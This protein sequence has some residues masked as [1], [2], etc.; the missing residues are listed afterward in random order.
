MHFPVLSGRLNKARHVLCAQCLAHVSARRIITIN[1]VA[2]RVRHG[3]VQRP[4]E[5]ASG[6]EGVAVP[7][8]TDAISESQQIR[9]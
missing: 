4:V 2:E 5:G 8:F 9:G 7:I 3:P 6:Q 1:V